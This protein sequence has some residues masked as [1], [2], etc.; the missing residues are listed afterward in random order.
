MA[1]R[2]CKHCGEEFYVANYAP[3]TPRTVCTICNPRRRYPRYS[4][5]EQQAAVNARYRARAKARR[6]AELHA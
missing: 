3:G 2:I 1:H 6:E 5:K 4:S